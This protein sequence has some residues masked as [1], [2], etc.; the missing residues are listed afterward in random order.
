MK[1]VIKGPFKGYPK[2]VL[3]R[4]REYHKSNPHVYRL[5][6]KLA[7]EMSETGRK[8]Y[9]AE[10]IVNV[11][12]WHH[13]LNSKGDPFKINNDFKPMYARLL[14]HRHP[15]LGEFFHFRRVRSLGIKSEEQRERE[16]M[17]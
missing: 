6:K 15:E 3:G 10:V 17:L 9:S 14:V 16:G 4:F 13:D 8:Q 11:M 5:F 1:I 12:R 7:F 2:K